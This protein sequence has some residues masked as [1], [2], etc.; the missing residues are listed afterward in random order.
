MAKTRQGSA[1]GTAQED[2]NNSPQGLVGV[3]QVVVEGIYEQAVALWQKKDLSSDQ[4]LFAELVA[5]DIGSSYHYGNG[6]P[7]IEA[8]S[9][10]AEAAR[11]RQAHE[12]NNGL[13]ALRI[14]C[15]AFQKKSPLSMELI[16][17]MHEALT[18]GTYDSERLAK[19]ERPGT[20][21]MHDYSPDPNDDSVGS[22]V[23][24]TEEELQDLLDEVQEFPDKKALTAAAY[25]HAKF[26]NIHPFADGNGR[27]GRLAM[28]YLLALHGHPPLSINIQNH[29]QYV[30]GLMQWNEQQ[31]I[32][33]LKKLFTHETAR[34]WSNDVVQGQNLLLILNRGKQQ[35]V[36]NQRTSSRRSAENSHDIA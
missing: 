26:E 29:L 27:T 9:P 36:E 25:F 31:E 32:S 20:F 17:E 4:D 15:D 1:Q 2:K 22:L 33:L 13:K 16:L 12:F 21:K 7:E 8:D 18:H 28:N 23:E 14:F 30:K 5:H 24:D 11:L 34:T 19:G 35:S 6:K 3:G 10:D